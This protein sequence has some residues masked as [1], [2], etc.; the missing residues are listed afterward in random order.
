MTTQEALK[1]AREALDDIYR[2]F[3]AAQIEG[4]A[5]ALAETS[6]ERLKDLVERRLLYDA[7]DTASDAI[8]AIDAALSQQAAQGCDNRLI[9]LAKSRADDIA[10]AAYEDGERRWRKRPLGPSP[11]F[12]LGP[13]AQVLIRALKTEIDMISAQQAAQE[14]QPVAYRYGF[15]S[16][17]DGGTVWRDS[18]STWNGQQPWCSEPLYAA[19]AKP[20]DPLQRLVDQAQ[21]LDMG[22]GKPAEAEQAPPTFNSIGIAEGWS[23]TV[24]ACG[25]RV[26]CISDQHYAGASDIEP[27]KETITTCAENLLAFIG[28][29]KSEQ[30][31]AGEVPA[32]GQCCYG[33]M[34]PK[35]ACASCAAWSMNGG[36]GAPLREAL[37][38]LR[39][40]C[41]LQGLRGHAGLDCW[42][43]MADKAL[44]TPPAV[45]P[46]HVIVPVEPTPEMIRAA[47][48]CLPPVSRKWHAA[49]KE[50]Y[51]AMLSVAPGGTHD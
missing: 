35:S 4:L 44:P 34:K 9:A 21:E 29:R 19:P 8:A 10:N 26:L 45:P 5:D 42:L 1:A 30:A 46:G 11:Q 17:F 28:L 24:E 41:E 31:P 16:P 2:C 15:R 43:A 40:E 36:I 12:P 39:N 33:G 14:P 32:L 22:Y 3:N 13:S 50:K 38:R 23:V 20:S 48:E 27:Y 7:P 6:D 25:E 51:A 49:I 47:H 18:P 37:Y